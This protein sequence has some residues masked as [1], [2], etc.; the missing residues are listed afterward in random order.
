MQENRKNATKGG[1]PSPTTQPVQVELDVYS[2]RPNPTWTLSTQET[3]E[4]LQRLQGLTTLLS[5]STV[6]HLGY[7]GFLLHNPGS[8]SGIGA[9][10]RV[11]HGII[12][13]TDQGR[14]ST[15]KDSH[16]LEQWLIEQ[17]RVHGEGEIL[18]AQEEEL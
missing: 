11:F 10:V 6:G 14:T 3:S 1:K 15:Y 18:K 4:L 13:I 17:A 12:I 8:L 9:Q 16:G 2:G 7:R 5:V